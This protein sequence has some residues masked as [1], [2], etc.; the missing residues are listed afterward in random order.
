MIGTSSR[1]RPG[2]TVVPRL[3]VGSLFL[4]CSFP[5]LS[6]PSCLLLS[7]SHFLL[8]FLSSS[9]LSTSIAR[10]L[11]LPTKSCSQVLI[12]DIP[13]R[14][15]PLPPFSAPSAEPRYPGP[16]LRYLGLEVQRPSPSRRTSQTRYEVGT[17]QIRVRRRCGRLSANE[18][19]RNLGSL[20]LSL[21]RLFR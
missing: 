21:P 3:L 1:V 12:I 18:R 16:G 13:R 14:T 19:S 9:I 7:L 6:I 15:C 11:S 2:A 10:Y 8:S 5:F 17:R 20:S 4:I